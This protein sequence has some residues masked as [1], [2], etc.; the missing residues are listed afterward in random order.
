[1]GSQRAYQ[2]SRDRGR[3]KGT[4]GVASA[5]KGRFE[6]RG[7]CDADPAR[8]AKSIKAFSKAKVYSDFR[9][10]LDKQKDIDAVTISAS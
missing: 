1:M 9:E 5:C 10:M 6:Y 7:S 3:G 2:R 4:A 8:G